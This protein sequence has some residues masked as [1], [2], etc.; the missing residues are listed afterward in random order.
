MEV[1][2]LVVSTVALLVSGLAVHYVRREARASETANVLTARMVDVEE[3]RRQAERSREA[4]IAIA[5]RKAELQLVYRGDGNQ[6]WLYVQNQG[7]A[8]A[9]HVR[10][11][12]ID[13]HGPG[14]APEI[15]PIVADRLG[16]GD[17]KEVPVWLAAEDPD[18]VDCELVWT[19]GAGSHR[20]ERRPVALHPE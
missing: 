18:E 11:A 3:D 10:V 19:D 13:A 2:A 15:E 14:T 12:V 1:A 20:L 8:E 17:R 4:A 5:A 6:G 7:P 16:V 9:T